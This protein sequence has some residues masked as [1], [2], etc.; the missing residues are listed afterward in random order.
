[1]VPRSVGDPMVLGGPFASRIKSRS[2]IRIDYSPSSRVCA[3]APP[4]PK[5]DVAL[6]APSAAAALCG[7]RMSRSNSHHKPAS[8]HAAGSLD[9]DLRCGRWNRR[10]GT[11][12]KFHWGLGFVVG[13]S[14][15]CSSAHN[16]SQIL[17]RWTH[18][19]TMRQPLC[20]GIKRNSSGW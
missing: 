5:R 12:R 17:I 16:R 14:A 18:L 19:T 9:T 4:V 2:R 13:E 7:G 15:G 11:E 8:R 1:M 6:H 3:Q 10:L 20:N